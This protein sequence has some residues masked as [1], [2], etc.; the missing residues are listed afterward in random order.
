MFPLAEAPAAPVPPESAAGG[1]PLLY[2]FSQ[3]IG[4]GRGL[5]PLVAVL[6]RINTPCA[7]RLR[8]LPAPG[9]PDALRGLARAAGF[10]GSLAFEPLGPPEAMM[11]LAASADLGLSLEQSTPL[12]RDLCLTNKIFTYLLA[13]MP[14]ALT[15]TSAQLGLAPAL[16]TAALCLDLARPAEAATVLDAFLGDPARRTSAR[17]AAWRLG[18]TRYHWEQEI[19]ALLASVETALASPAP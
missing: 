12:N 7:L 19:P 5:E 2:W 16:G 11:T 6:G 18:R 9:F 14:V 4:P 10:T 1:A 13:G 3:T 15:P 8:G 17:S